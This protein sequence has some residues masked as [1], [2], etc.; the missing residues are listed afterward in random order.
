M[1]SHFKLLLTLFAAVFLAACSSSSDQQKKSADA[2]RAIPPAPEKVAPAPT[3]V[4]APPPAAA[5]EEKVKTFKVRFNTSKGPVLIEVHPDWAPLGA[6]QFRKLVQAKYFD[7]VRFFRVVPNFVVQ[8]GLAANPTVT[9]KW[10]V[11]LKDDPVTQTN[12][13]G[14]LSFATM[15]P[16]TRTTQIF[17]NLTSNASLDGQGFAPFAQVIEGMEIVERFYSGYGERPDQG[18]ITAEGNAYLEKSFPDLDYIKTAT[19]L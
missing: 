10:D 17:I 6:E 1:R 18:A 19:I 13:T 12:R 11:A 5:P 2:E 3:P 14:A 9:K 16:G 4:P 7:G 15:G 8:F